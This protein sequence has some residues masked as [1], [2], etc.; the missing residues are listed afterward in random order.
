MS[1]WR[2][3]SAVVL[4]SLVLLAPAASAGA[5]PSAAIGICQTYL[6]SILRL[7]DNTPTG[8]ANQGQCIASIMGGQDV[9]LVL[10]TSQE[11]AAESGMGF[12]LDASGAIEQVVVYS[13]D[14]EGCVNTV[15]VFDLDGNVVARVEAE[16]GQLVSAPVEGLFFH[17]MPGRPVG[18]TGDN[19]NLSGWSIAS[20]GACFPA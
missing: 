12:V 17:P 18:L 5:E 19:S 10:G 15:E 4:A 14:L 6:G 20:T 11:G 9:L 13:A 8:F 7:P 1:T 3:L 2:R 16:A